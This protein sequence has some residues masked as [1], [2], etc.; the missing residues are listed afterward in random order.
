MLNYRVCPLSPML[1][2]IAHHVQTRPRQCVASVQLSRSPKRWPRTAC[3]LRSKPRFFDVPCA[4][5]T[6]RARGSG[7]PPVTVVDGA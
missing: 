4:V 1:I 6:A 7:R 5:L 3:R 2:P